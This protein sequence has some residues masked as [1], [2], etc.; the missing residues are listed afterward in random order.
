M[1][2]PLFSDPEVLLSNFNDGDF[3]AFSIVFYQYYRSVEH[4]TNLLVKDK[5]LADSIVLK[6]FY[7]LRSRKH[8]F[9]RMDDIESYILYSV[10]SVYLLAS[11]ERNNEPIDKVNVITYWDRSQSMKMNINTAIAALDKLCEE[12]KESPELEEFHEETVK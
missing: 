12:S 1:N 11:K 7:T 3:N 2:Y 10:Y 6:I 5:K 4:F 8:Y 9:K